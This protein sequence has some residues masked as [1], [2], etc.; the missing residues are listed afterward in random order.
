[1]RQQLKRQFLRWYFDH[2]DSSIQEI[3]EWWLDVIYGKKN[4]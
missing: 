2:E 4:E 1:M 3:A